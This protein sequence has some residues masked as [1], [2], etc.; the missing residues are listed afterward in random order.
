MAESHIEEII[1]TEST[2][3]DGTKG[4]PFRILTEYFNKEGERLFR[5]DSWE[6]AGSELDID[7]AHGNTWFV[8]KRRTSHHETPNN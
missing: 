4:N 8:A 2:T 5:R 3:G 7:G 1:V 6:G